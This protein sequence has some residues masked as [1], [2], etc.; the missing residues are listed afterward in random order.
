M[1]KGVFRTLRMRRTS[2][3]SPFSAASM[4]CK[5]NKNNNKSNCLSLMLS[6]HHLW[7]EFLSKEGM[8]IGKAST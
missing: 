3:K 2:E 1:E 7:G 4:A 8:E 5:E 6:K